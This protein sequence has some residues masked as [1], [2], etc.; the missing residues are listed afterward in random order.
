MNKELIKQ[1]VK[2]MFFLDE[3]SLHLEVNKNKS[4][5]KT[6]D[7]RISIKDESGNELDY[8]ETIIDLE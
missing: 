7:I 2:E 4:W 3:L 8:S 5:D 6:L 1:T